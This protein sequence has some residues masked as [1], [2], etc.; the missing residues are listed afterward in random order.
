MNTTLFV[1]S[2]PKDFEWLNYSIQSMEKYISGIYETVLVIPRG[3]DISQQM[4]NFFDRIIFSQQEDD[5]P[6]YIAQ[7]LDKLDAHKYIDT[8]Y[9]LYSDSDCIYTG[10]FE[11]SLLFTKETIEYNNPSRTEIINVLPILNMTP[12]SELGN[13]VPWQRVVEQALGF[14]PVYEFM[15]CFPIIH[16]TETVAALA[17]DHPNLK[18]YGRHIHN[19]A[20][21]EFNFIGAYAYRNRHPYF[22]TE[23]CL[24]LPC[25][26]G[27]SWGGISPEIRSKIETYLKD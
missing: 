23:E 3:S 27:W 7:Q 6:G 14:V 5:I 20:F 2:Y 12:Y 18:E 9:I 26:Q 22:Y 15:R 21:S 13:T 17:K 8:D 11:P 4:V 24:P 1:R 10:P 16:R 25:W 19:K